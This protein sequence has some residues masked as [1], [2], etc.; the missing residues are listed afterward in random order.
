M[1]SE[2]IP[3]KIVRRKHGM[4]WLKKS[5]CQM[6]LYEREQDLMLECLEKEEEDDF[7]Y[8]EDELEEDVL[9]T[10]QSDSDTE[11]EITDVEN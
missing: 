4:K 9:E 10:R 8:A 7:V 6:A 5:T 1:I 11:Q 2:N 3:G